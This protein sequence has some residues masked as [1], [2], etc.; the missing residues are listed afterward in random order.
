MQ[1]LLSLINEEI[2]YVTIV[3][4]GK[5]TVQI[6]VHNSP[7]FDKFHFS[8]DHQVCS[9]GILFYFVPLKRYDAK[10]KTVLYCVQVMF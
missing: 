10:R 7:S 5:A 6:S 1:N 8:Y 9:E 2:V 4:A 3:K